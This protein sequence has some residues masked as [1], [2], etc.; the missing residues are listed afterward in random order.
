M[1]P[2]LRTY[3]TGDQVRLPYIESYT[4]RVETKVDNTV[5]DSTPL[6]SQVE[7]IGSHTFVDQGRSHLNP[8]PLDRGYQGT[9]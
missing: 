9:K 1:V 5:E 2:F 6:E 3:A 7:L 4:W 8:T